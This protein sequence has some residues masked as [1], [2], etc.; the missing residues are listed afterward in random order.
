MLFR[1]LTAESFARHP[2]VLDGLRRFWV[3]VTWLDAGGRIVATVPEREG[4]SAASVLDSNGRVK[5]NETDD[6]SLA[7]HLNVLLPKQ[8]GQYTGA[9]VVRYSAADLLKSKTPWWLAAKYDVRLVDELDEVFASNVNTPRA[10]WQEWYRVS[11]GNTLPQA[12]LELS[13]R[14]RIRPW[15]HTLPMALMLG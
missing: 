11:M 14:D 1:S 7:G 12:W 5:G 4:D 9:L 6:K 2:L 3:S 8:H 15:W 13:A 10:P